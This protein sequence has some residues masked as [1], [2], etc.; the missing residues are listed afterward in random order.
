MH[1]IR[2]CCVIS[3][4]LVVGDAYAVVCVVRYF[5]DCGL[6]AVCCSLFCVLCAIHCVSWCGVCCVVC[7]VNLVGVGVLR[8]VYNTVCCELFDV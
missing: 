3:W 8:D 5:V 4:L 7:V 6:Y 2:C 1:S